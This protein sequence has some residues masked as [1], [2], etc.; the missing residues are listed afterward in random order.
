MTRLILAPLLLLVASASASTSMLTV[1]IGQAVCGITTDDAT[2]YYAG[3][4]SS[5]ARVES[6]TT[7]FACGLQ[8]GGGAFFCWP[9]AAPDQLRR[10]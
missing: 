9:T 6:N 7:V 3:S 8:T 2:V 1:A 5:S 4:N 10:E